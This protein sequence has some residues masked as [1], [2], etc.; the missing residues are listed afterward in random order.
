MRRQAAGTAGKYGLT[1][2]KVLDIDQRPDPTCLA[3]QR[4]VGRRKLMF[5]N[6]GN[7]AV[8]KGDLTVYFH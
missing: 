5:G 1:A 4:P 8:P 3:P 2:T 7:A 6:A